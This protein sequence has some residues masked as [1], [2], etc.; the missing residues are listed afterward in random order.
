MFLVAWEG[1][2]T[3]WLLAVREDEDKDEVYFQACT[4]HETD[5][6]Y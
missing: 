2:K 1:C 5:F 4:F 3:P 6:A